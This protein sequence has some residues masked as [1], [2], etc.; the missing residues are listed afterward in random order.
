MR[1]N[2]DR[3]D[4]DGNG[5]L[6]A[7]EIQSMMQAHPQTEIDLP[8]PPVVSL[9]ETPTETAYS[10]LTKF[11]HRWSGVFEAFDANGD[12]LLDQRELSAMRGRS[13]GPG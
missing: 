11:P 10:A 12:G 4:Q 13:R 6:D 5:Y 2:F 1:R 3:V 7:S 8:A 9:G